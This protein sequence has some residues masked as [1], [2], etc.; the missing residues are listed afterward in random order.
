MHFNVLP[1]FVSALAIALPSEVRHTQ[2]RALLTY[3]ALY[4]ATLTSLECVD[5]S[6]SLISDIQFVLHTQTHLVYHDIRCK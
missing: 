4:L 6:I 3:Q 1:L 2:S 5:A